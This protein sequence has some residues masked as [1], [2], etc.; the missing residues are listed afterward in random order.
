MRLWITRIFD[1]LKDCWHQFLTA[2]PFRTRHGMRL[3]FNP[4]RLPK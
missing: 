2:G 3:Y 4:L 1:P